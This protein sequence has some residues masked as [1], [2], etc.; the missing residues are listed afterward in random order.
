MNLW[1]IS[2]NH[3]PKICQT[4]DED[5]INQSDRNDR[6]PNPNPRSS[7]SLLG[8]WFNLSKTALVVFSFRATSR[9]NSF[10]VIAALAHI[11]IHCNTAKKIKSISKRP[12]LVY[13]TKISFK[14]KQDKNSSNFYFSQKKVM[15]W[16][17]VVFSEILG[18]FSN[19]PETRNA[20]RRLRR[21]NLQP[22]KRNRLILHSRNS[23]VAKK[24]P[25]T[26]ILT[27]WWFQPIWKILV[28]L[29]HFP[30]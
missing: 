30:K 2:T 9:W 12:T 11:R 26:N 27:S 19:P 28:K 29:D 14:Q 16:A 3:R 18:I 13:V 24:K 22:S 10:R 15:T 17:W 1:W 5:S 6:V 8:G 7:E 20:W 21:W 25:E 4:W 23:R